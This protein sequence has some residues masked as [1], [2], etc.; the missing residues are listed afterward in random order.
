MRREWF[1]FTSSQTF[2]QRT[3]QWWDGTKLARSG[4]CDGD[5]DVDEQNSSNVRSNNGGRHSLAIFI[6]KTAGQDGVP[7]LSLSVSDVSLMV[8]FIQAKSWQD[9]P[10]APIIVVKGLIC[11]SS[12]LA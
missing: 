9:V 8:C 4:E 11:K 3:G 6:C 2:V 1:E 10:K 5:G 12:K 7:S